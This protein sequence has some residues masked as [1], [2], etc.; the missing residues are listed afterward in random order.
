MGLH[1]SSIG[2]PSRTDLRENFWSFTVYDNDTRSLL[3][4]DQKLAG[5]DSAL[6]GVRMNPDGGVTIWFGPKAPAGHEKQVRYGNL[7]AAELA[8]VGPDDHVQQHL[9]RVADGRRVAR[10][11]PAPQKLS[12]TTVF[13]AIPASDISIIE[14]CRPWLSWVNCTAFGAW[15][16]GCRC[17][18]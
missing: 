16:E 9:Q 14:A 6:P 1:P 8:A 7:N 18:C 15:T 3:P 17:G 11:F 12:K 5:L 4:T 2:D 10:Q 13:S